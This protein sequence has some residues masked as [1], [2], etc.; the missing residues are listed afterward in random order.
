MGK[1]THHDAISLVGGLPTV[2]SK[3]E[4]SG[5]KK[6]ALVVVDVSKQPSMASTMLFTLMALSSR[7]QFSAKARVWDTAGQERYESISDDVP[8]IRNEDHHPIERHQ[9]VIHAIS[10]RTIVLDCSCG[11]GCE[12]EHTDEHKP[13][14]SSCG[15]FGFGPQRD[16]DYPQRCEVCWDDPGEGHR[17]KKDNRIPSK[18]KMQKSWRG[19]GSMI[20]RNLN[21]RGTARKDTHL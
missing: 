8:K 11:S 13:K 2:Y 20:R 17:T 21:G 14:K 4:V 19:K 5:G 6:V 18:R 15:G 3:D 7:S 10:G 16:Y 1:I 9:I 12:S